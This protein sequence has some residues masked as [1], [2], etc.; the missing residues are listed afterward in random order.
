ME[1]YTYKLQN[2]SPTKPGTFDKIDVIENYESL[3]WTER[4][5]G[6]SE[7][8]M[9]CPIKS[10]L[11]EKLPVDIFWGIDDSE[12]LLILDTINV[13]NN[14]LVFNA[15]SV[16][17][18]LN[19]RFIRYSKLHKKQTKRFKTLPPGQLVWQI[20]Y[21]MINPN[22]SYLNP[23]SIGIAANFITK[24]PIPEISLF[25]FDSS[26]EPIIIDVSYGPLYDAIKNIAMSYQI[27]M[28]IFLQT[29]VNINA[30]TPLGFRSYKGLNK[31]RTQD[32]II[33]PIVRFSQDLNSLENM[34]QILSKAIYKT[35]VFSFAANLDLELSDFDFE[36]AS[37]VAY[38]EET[39]DP[40]TF[41]GFN[42]R[43][44]Q[45]FSDTAEYP[46]TP[47]APTDDDTRVVFDALNSLAKS[48]LEQ[49]ILIEA[50]DGDIVANNMFQYGRDYTLGDIVELEGIDGTIS[51]IRVTEHIIS[52]DS[53]GEKGSVTTGS[54]SEDIIA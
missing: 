13:E 6:D 16:L 39:G 5:Y 52:E 17:T 4:Y 21:D 27:G 44:S 20:L 23:D 37:G 43:A 19:N 46:T 11:L 45:V 14:R 8:Q 33:N 18:W 24:L 2:T 9:I 29:K 10:D 3:I 42:C 35:I 28:K 48:T 38:L 30:E 40:N 41:T 53:G 7:A 36:V 49:S 50:V 1:L 54:L 47:D 12:E 32:P 34:R 15:I 22:S 51:A 31:T 26:G 25:E